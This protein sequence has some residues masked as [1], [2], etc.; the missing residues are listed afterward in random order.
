MTS[1]HISHPV[2]DFDEWLA[3]FNTFGDFRAQGGVTGLTVRHAT[4]DPNF[5]AVD[6]EFA[7]AAEAG[8]FLERLETEIWPSSPLLDGQP[9]ARILDTVSVTA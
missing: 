1:L 6:L 2:S 7:N 4:D 5:V 3:T 9:T 8:A